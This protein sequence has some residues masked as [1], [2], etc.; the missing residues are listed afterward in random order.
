[1]TRAHA[2]FP[3][4]PR[5]RTGT[6]TLEKTLRDI[7]GVLRVYVNRVTEMAYV[8][9]DGERCDEHV[10]ATA[11]EREGCAGDVMKDHRRRYPDEHF[12]HHGRPQ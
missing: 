11:L 8:E 6:T 12:I 3:I 1:M 5:G 10:L 2:T 7:P 9:Y 4:D